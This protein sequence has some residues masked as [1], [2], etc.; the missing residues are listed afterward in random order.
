MT[1]LCIF[2]SLFLSWLLGGLF[3]HFLVYLLSRRMGG[4][5][6]LDP[7]LILGIAMGLFGQWNISE[8][9]IRHFSEKSSKWGQDF[10]VRFPA[11]W[12]SQRQRWDGNSSALVLY[13]NNEQ[14]SINGHI[15][16]ARN[17]LFLVFGHWDFGVDC[18]YSKMEWILMDIEA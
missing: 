9:N 16:G 12:W 14:S 11:S 3:I 13:I 8:S 2:N 4:L 6:F 10:H 17:K 5:N 1:H 15:A 18:N 7:P